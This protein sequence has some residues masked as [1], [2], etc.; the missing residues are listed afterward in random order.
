M[1]L[2][3]LSELLMLLGL[4]YQRSNAGSTFHSR[5]SKLGTYLKTT[6]SSPSACR[7]TEQENPKSFHGFPR[8]FTMLSVSICCIHIG[9]QCNNL[10]I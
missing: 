1:L 9:A 8:I 10:S 6:S 5:T 4:N 7:D 2:L 3:Q